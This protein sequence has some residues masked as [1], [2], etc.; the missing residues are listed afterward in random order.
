MTTKEARI[1][2][3]IKKLQ[4]LKY[5]DLASM[6]EVMSKAQELLNELGNEEFKEN[7]IIN[8]LMKAVVFYQHTLPTGHTIATML[9]ELQRN[10]NSDQDHAK[11]YL[12][13]SKA[14]NH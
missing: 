6:A 13:L 9:Q 12:Q 3:T 8:I 7:I 14:I 5:T 2:V 4:E 1:I 10:P 11:I